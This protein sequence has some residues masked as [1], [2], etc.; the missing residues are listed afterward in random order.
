M[1]KLVLLFSL[2]LLSSSL[3]EASYLDQQLNELDKNVIYQTPQQHT[4]NYEQNKEYSVEIAEGVKD[5]KLLEFAKYTPIDEKLYQQKLSKD[6]I[7]YEKLIIPALK[8]KTQTIN[9]EPEA[10]DFYNVY[11]ITE[12]LI[13]ANNLDYIN[14]RV[15]IRKTPVSNAAAFDGNYIVINTGLYDSVYESEDALAYVIAHEMAH[16]ILG[17]IQ[18]TQELNYTLDYFDKLITANN[19]SNSSNAGLNKLVVESRRLGIYKE[20][21]KME[22]MADTQAL[23]LITRAGYS[24]YKGL[25][26]LNFLNTFNNLSTIVSTHP[27]TAERIASYNENIAVLDPNWKFVGRENIYNSDVLNCKKSSDRVSIV[28]SKSKKAKQFYQVETKEQRLT[29][30][31]HVKYLRGE[32]KDAVKYF[33]QLAEIQEDNYIPYV[34]ISLANEYTFNKTGKKKFMKWAKKAIVKAAELK[35]DAPQVLSQL[36]NLGLIGENKKQKL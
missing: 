35:P 5:P 29:R 28:I 20:F 36:E 1:K 15:A 30:L 22:Y 31:A 17:H 11:R 21:R 3:A 16:H 27:S 18:R 2:L 19:R 23:E 24:P 26:T 14:W 8:K 9:M 32:M 10:V 25:E 4:K 6:A 7:K 12:R 34:Y 13:R 33:A